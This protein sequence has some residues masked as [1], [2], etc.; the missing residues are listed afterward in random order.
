MYVIYYTLLFNK[1][2]IPYISYLT[3]FLFNKALSYNILAMESIIL[4][5]E[6]KIWYNF[7]NLKNFNFIIRTSSLKYQKL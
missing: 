6:S 2:I 7:T 1:Y 4:D 3:F 5:F